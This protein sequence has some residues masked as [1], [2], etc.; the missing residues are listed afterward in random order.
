MAGN[1]DQEEFRCTGRKPTPDKTQLNVVKL[2]G[3]QAARLTAQSGWRWSS[4]SSLWPA[5]TN[6]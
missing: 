5:P 4:A 1:D 6:R 2:G 3:V